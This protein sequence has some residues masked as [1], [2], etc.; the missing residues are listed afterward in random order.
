MHRLCAHPGMQGPKWSATSDYLSTMA[1]P[2]LGAKVLYEPSSGVRR[3]MIVYAMRL[4]GSVLPPRRCR[5]ASERVSWRSEDDERYDGSAWKERGRASRRT[6]WNPFLTNELELEKRS[7][8]EFAKFYVHDF[9][10][11][12]TCRR[13]PRDFSRRQS[14]DLDA[15]VFWKSKV[16]FCFVPGVSSPWKK[17]HLGNMFFYVF[18]FPTIWNKSK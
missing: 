1:Y 6:H 17:H 11:W 2:E 16:M 5:P 3:E 12:S 10:S 14:D 13:E 8:Q 9:H 7:L 18:S 15:F 4:D